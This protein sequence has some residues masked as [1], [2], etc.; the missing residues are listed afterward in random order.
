[1]KVSET[2]KK[3]LKLI[4]YQRIFLLHGELGAGK[5][6]LTKKIAKKLKI[7]ET[8]TSP[9]F[10][11]WQKY[12]FRLKKRKYFLNHLDLYRIKID[13]IL[14]IDLKKEIKKEDNI[15]F[16][17]WG[18]KLKSYLKKKKIAYV[19]VIIQKEGRK[20]NYLVKNESLFD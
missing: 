19:E 17:E 2:I 10:V 9:T 11:L 14:K 4:P 6:T 18:E 5:T 20:R 13:D 7:K 3:I 15:F 1:M 12:E 16:I 8:L